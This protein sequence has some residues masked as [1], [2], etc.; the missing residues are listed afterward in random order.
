MLIWKG[1]KLACE[2]KS[3]VG[4]R[5]ELGELEEPRILSGPQHRVKRRPIG[6][7]F[8]LSGRMGSLVITQEEKDVLSDC[9]LNILLV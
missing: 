4:E 3:F 7:S 5:E 9:Q 1:T 2:L 8:S 6:L